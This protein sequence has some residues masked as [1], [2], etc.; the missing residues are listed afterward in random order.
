[1]AENNSPVPEDTP[2]TPLIYKLPNEL[3]RTVVSHVP[4]RH[5]VFSVKDANGNRKALGYTSFF[6]LMAV[7]RRFRMIAQEDDRWLDEDFTFDELQYTHSQP[8]KEWLRKMIMV[9][10]LL[11]DE[12]LRRTL[13]RKTRWKIRDLDIFNLLLLNLPQFLQTMQAVTLE[14]YKITGLMLSRLS[15]CPKITELRL[16]QF[17]V[18]LEAIHYGCPNL[19]SLQIRQVDSYQKTLHH[20][21]G[22]R[23]L[24][25]AC[26]NGIPFADALIPHRSASTLTSL[27]L[28]EFNGISP[29]VLEGRGFS[30]LRHLE[31]LEIKPIDNQ[32]WDIIPTIPSQ[33]SSLKVMAE[34]SERSLQQII[35]K[36]FHADYFKRL[37]T[38]SLTF[39][40]VLEEVTRWQTVHQR[41]C[42]RIVG[43]IGGKLPI[44]T[45]LELGMSILPTW[46]KM[47]RRLTMLKQ[48]S[49]ILDIEDLKYM[50]SDQGL[51][52]RERALTSDGS[53]ET[54]SEMVPH[55][56]N[57][58]VSEFESV[59]L[60]PTIQ[61][62]D[63]KLIELLE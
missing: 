5:D 27:S 36:L 17:E 34:P 18:N 4:H 12:H 49:L 20:Q 8:P 42:Q 40:E 60:R 39:E 57:I 28:I 19:K 46:C 25:I 21:T 7:S 16:A 61:I 30:H 58:L 14:T 48:L 50:G 51:G 6:A 52:E 43:F 41:Y 11:A 22:L 26:D 59:R 55:I 15:L 2:P 1:M 23:N 53:M 54:F 47:L 24:R 33:L 56:R 9:Q 3:L 13:S 45:H 32:F 29:N 37:R 44:L 38:F 62:Y 10:A 63:C 31:H 35:A